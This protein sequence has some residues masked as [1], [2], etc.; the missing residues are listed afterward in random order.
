MFIGRKQELQDLEALYARKD[1]EMVVIYGR[2]RVGKTSLIDEFVRGKQVLYVTALQQSSKL[3]LELFSQEVYRCFGIPEG[4]PGFAD[5]RSALNYVV[6]RAREVKAGTRKPFI[7]VFDE[8]PYAAQAE[9]ALPS[10]L[11]I[12]I[13]HGFKNTPVMIILSGSNQGFMESEVLGSKSPLFGRRTA[14]IKLQPF[15]YYDAAQFLP[16]ATATEKVE[17]YATFG[18]TP[19]YLERIDSAKSYRENVIDLVYSKLGM[20]SEEPMMLLREEMREPAIY[21]SAMQ[22]IAAGSNTPKLIAE[23][24]GLEVS[25]IGKYLKSLMGLGLVKRLVPFGENPIKTRKSLYVVG[26]PFFAYWFRFVAPKASI[27]ETGGGAALA[28]SSAFGEVFATYVGGQFE[29]VCR[30]WLV[31]KNVAEELPFVATGFGKW[32]GND[33]AAHEQ[34]DIDVVAANDD[35]KRIIIGECK[36]R[37]SFNETEAI[38]K[39]KARAGLVKGFPVDRTGFILFSKNRVSKPTLEHYRN[40]ERMSLIAAD[41]LYC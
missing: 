28:K 20:L 40:D 19:Y 24:A 27:I 17:Y 1:Y 37:N 32:W 14:Q 38:D 10:L 31:R 23:R 3:N 26:D 15:D 8:F 11:Q 12:A 9:P 41:D 4:T 39:L 29:D 6:A 18:G 5:W 33:P 13:D 25:A 2:R 22:A 36:W 21:Y 35:E 30:Q 7:F 34:T 16:K